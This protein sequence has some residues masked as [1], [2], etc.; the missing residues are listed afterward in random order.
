MKSSSQEKA[1]K[2]GNRYDF[3]IFYEVRNVDILRQQ[4]DTIRIGM[5]KLHP[6]CSRF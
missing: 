5:M 3:V 6:N 1:D 2:T 4:L